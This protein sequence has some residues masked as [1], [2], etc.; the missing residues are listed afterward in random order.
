MKH[1]TK[2]RQKVKHGLL[3]HFILDRLYEI[4]FSF[5]PFYLVQEGTQHNYDN[6]KPRIKPIESRFLTTEEIEK[7]SQHPEVGQTRLQL[8]SRLE[9]GCKC[10]G[11]F[12]NDQIVAYMW[13]NFTKCESRISFPLKSNE[14]YLFDAVSLKAFRGN[15]LAPFLRNQLYKYLTDK[16]FN[17]IYSITDAFNTSAANFKKKIGAINLKLFVQF[18]FFKYQ[19]VILLKELHPPR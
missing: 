15:N 11:V 4:G 19:K 2:I 12:N 9:K 17:R 3:A 16:N 5:H 14:A 6:V 7:L 10:F 1:L 13:C 18:H 8:M